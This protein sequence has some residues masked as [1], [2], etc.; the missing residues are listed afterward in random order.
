ME[1]L[2]KDS[3]EKELVKDCS[4]PQSK[5]KSN[6][7]A[8]SA[9]PVPAGAG[10]WRGLGGRRLRRLRGPR[11]AHGLGGRAAA[12]AAQRGAAGAERRRWSAGIQGRAVEL[13]LAG[14]GHPRF[15]WKP[16]RGGRKQELVVSSVFICCK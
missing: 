5:S 10:R 8:K 7:K 2:S 16:M 14:F 1:C 13:P 4:P 15:Q 3:S 6:A 12:A 9:R 11:G